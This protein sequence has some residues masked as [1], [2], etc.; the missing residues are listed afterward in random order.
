MRGTE[1]MAAVALAAA[2]L[3]PAVADA[4][5]PPPRGWWLQLDP[6]NENDLGVVPQEGWIAIPAEFAPT[7]GIES[8]R[9]ALDALSVEVVA[10]GG[11]E[12]PGTLEWS[13]ALGVPVWKSDGILEPANFHTLQVFVDPELYGGPAFG[14]RGSAKLTFIS[15]PEPLAPLE[16]ASLARIEPLTEWAKSLRTVSCA[17]KPD[18]CPPCGAV[19]CEMTMTVEYDYLPALRTEWRLGPRPELVVHHLWSV[20]DDQPPKRVHTLRDLEPGLP[21]EDGPQVRPV[22]IPFETEGSTYCVYVESVRLIDGATKIG[23]TICTGDGRVPIE[24]LPIDYGRLE[25]CQT[26]P[27]GY[28]VHGPLPEVEEAGGTLPPVDYGGCTGTSRSVGPVWSV[29]LLGALL[30]ARRRRR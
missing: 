8:G 22:E 21:P 15:A 11:I 1:W 25:N 17:L 24:R 4:C 12:V 28:D 10:A 13:E 5:Q 26:L 23:E 20:V 16:P 19:A 29:L 14:H 7:A 6:E 30:S 2:I 18:R 27:E 9:E 3:G